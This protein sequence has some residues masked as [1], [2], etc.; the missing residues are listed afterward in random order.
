[1]LAEQDTQL[2][3]AMSH[4]KSEEA[5]REQS[6]RR[7]CDESEELSS[8][9]SMLKAAEMNKARATQ[10]TEKAMIADND[11]ARQQHIDREM[12]LDRQAGLALE[13][14]DLERRQ[15]INMQSRGV[16]Q[17]QMADKERA[18]K[19]KKD[20]EAQDAKQAKE[21]KEA[22]AKAAKDAK[23]AKDAKAKGG[24][25]QKGGKEP[26]APGKEAEQPPPPPPQPTQGQQ[27]SSKHAT[28]YQ[29]RSLFR[30]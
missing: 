21:A 28:F 15:L 14:A 11:K 8:L 20:K 16:L 7:I 23:D 22:K 25:D 5:A 27:P 2:A 24:K 17:S 18:R 6:H 9:R 26:K 13:A 29:V 1:M 30:S 4:L 3:A 12:E 10:L 19:E